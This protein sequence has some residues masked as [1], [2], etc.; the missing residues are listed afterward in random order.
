M[1]TIAKEDLRGRIEKVY[2]DTEVNP[3]QECAIGV[4]N[5]AEVLVTNGAKYVG[6]DCLVKFDIN[7]NPDYDDRIPIGNVITSNIPDHF[8]GISQDKYILYGL[9]TPDMKKVGDVPTIEEITAYYNPG[10][11][12]FMFYLKKDSKA[13]KGRF[14][15]KSSG[16]FPFHITVRKLVTKGWRTPENLA[17]VVIAES[18]KQLKEQVSKEVY[19]HGMTPIWMEA[20][21]G[22]L[23]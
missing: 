5:R 23:D 14:L 13:A 22:S 20:L 10:D 6:K 8:K 15:I 16:A 17:K 19:Y 11:A 2:I 21:I 12:P 1:K 18:E 7:L 9:W 3:S 4:L